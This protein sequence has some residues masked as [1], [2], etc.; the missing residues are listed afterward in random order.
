MKLTEI[1]PV[2]LASQ[3]PRRL[4]ILR[5]HGIEPLVRPSGADET[6]PEDIRPEDA[7]MTLARRKAAACIDEHPEL[8]SEP[9][10]IIIAADTIVYKDEILGKPADAEDAFRMLSK[11]RGT[12]HS[13]LTGV[14]LIRLSDGQEHHFYE[15]TL[16]WC[17][18]YSDSDIRE[19]IET[20][21]PYDKAGAYAIQGAFAKYIDHI[22]G[23][24]ENVVG[25][26]YPRLA[27]EAESF[28]AGV[29]THIN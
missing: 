10:G 26:P 18:D 13:V 9:G 3:S 25:L 14:S 7:V 28:F 1:H 4:E 27:A 19:Y 29:Q 16:V 2:V 20:A 21:K 11:Y 17:R 12:S 22:E 5:N 8:R 24:Y 23:D 15:N 6:L